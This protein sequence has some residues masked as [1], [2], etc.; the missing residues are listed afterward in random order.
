MDNNTI[1]I[2]RLSQQGYP[3]SQIMIKMGLAIKGVDNPDLVRAMQGLAVGC[4]T[5]KTTCGALTGACC[6]ISLFGGRA[7]PDEYPHENLQTIIAD[8]VNWFETTYGGV[9]GGMLCMQIRQE[10]SPAE[11][12]VRCGEIIENT[13]NKAIEL[14]LAYDLI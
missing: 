9:Y 4:F 11:K 10:G 8:L 13:Y 7:E 6:L 3:C 2:M 5:E 12:K 14:L 1:Q